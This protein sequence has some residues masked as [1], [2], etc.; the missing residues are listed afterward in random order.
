M[1]EAGKCDHFIAAWLIAVSLH[2]IMHF[3]EYH[4]EIRRYVKSH[5]SR[6]HCPQT[7]E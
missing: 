7:Y 3:G 6:M 5:A 4:I 2:I 1:L